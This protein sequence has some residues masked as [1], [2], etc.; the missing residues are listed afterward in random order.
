MVLCAMAII[1][2]KTDFRELATYQGK[3]RLNQEL[4]KY[5]IKAK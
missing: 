4:Y 2:S 1:M 5:V 3:E